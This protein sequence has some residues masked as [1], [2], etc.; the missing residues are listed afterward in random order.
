MPYRDEPRPLFDARMMLHIQLTAI[1]AWLGFRLLL[2]GDT[3]ASTPAWRYFDEVASE[4]GWGVILVICGAIGALG[5]DTPRRWLKMFTILLLA[6]MH[7]LLAILFWRGNPAGG[8]PGI[9]VI[10]ACSGYYLAWRQAL[11]II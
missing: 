11:G 10:I 9:F 5:I 1:L 6:T 4:N 3:F 8:A 2:P 7:G